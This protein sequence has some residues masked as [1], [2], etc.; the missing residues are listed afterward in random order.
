MPIQER[1]KRFALRFMPERLLQN[2]KKIHYARS[3][4]RSTEDAEPDLRVL[5]HLVRPNARVVDLGANIGLYTKFLSGLVGPLGKVFSIEPVPQTYELLAS[6]IDALGLINVKLL[7]VAI[8]SLD[9]SVRMQVPHYLTGGENFYESHIVE[10][11]DDASLRTVEVQART[12]DSI[13]GPEDRIEFVKCDVEGHE[14]SCLRGAAE[15]LRSSRPAWL[16]EVS[17]NPDQRDSA[18]AD[19]FA[20]MAGHGYEPYWFD[21]ALLHRRQAGTRSVNYFFLT[22]AHVMRMPPALFNRGQGDM[23]RAA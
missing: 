10:E 5:R 1:L 9:G 2:F 7:N 20:I 15:L 21:G 13:F 16:I 14:R 23:R 12:L 22:Q 3:L 17:G 4:R 6:N 8:S 11:G 18:A 19:V